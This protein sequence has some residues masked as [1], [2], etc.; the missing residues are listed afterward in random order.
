MAINLQKGQSIILDKS[1]YDL[2]LLT[3]GLGWDVA[4]SKKGLAGLISGRS[5]FD[6]DGYALLL[7]SDGRVRD[8]KQDV[9][10]YGHLRSSDGTV[11]HSGDNLTGEGEGDDEQIVIRPNDLPAKYSKIVLGVSIYDAANRRQHFGMVE[12]AFVRAVDAN[13]VEIARYSLSGNESYEGQISMLMGELYRE[14]NQWKFT[15]LGTPSD[16]DLNRVVGSFM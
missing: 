8:Y 15:A 7:E 3:T 5:D 4:K 6:L 13:D 11:S 14:G 1:E 10:Y 2:S 9:I 12:N 16:K